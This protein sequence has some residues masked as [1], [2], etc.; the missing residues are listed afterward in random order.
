[1]KTLLNKKLTAFI[2]TAVLYIATANAQN[3]FPSNGRAEFLKQ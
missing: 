3:L 2:I 1:M